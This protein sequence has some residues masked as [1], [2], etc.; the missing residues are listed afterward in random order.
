MDI[1]AYRKANKALATAEQLSSG[2]DHYEVDGLDLKIYPVGGGSPLVMTFTQPA[3]GKDG[4]DGK[5]GADGVSI[6]GVEVDANNRLIVTYSE[7]SPEVAGTIATV[8]GDK[9][10]PGVPG[11]AGADG[12][13]FTIK[14]QYP[15]EAALIAAHPTGQEGDAYFVGDDTNPDL[16]IWLSDDAEWYNAGKIAGIKGDKGDKGDPGEGVPAGGTT[17]QV[18]T[19]KSGSDYDAEW[20]NPAGG[21]TLDDLTD[22]DIDNPADGEALVYNNTSGKWENKD[23]ELGTAAALDVPASGDASTTEVVKGDDSR[24]TDARTPVSH[25]HTLSQVTDAGTAAAKD[26][27][28]TITQGSTDLIESGAVY[29]GLAGK[30]D[31]SSVGT[32]SGVAE[33]DAY[34]KVPASQLPSYVD[35]VVEGYYKEADGKFYE[36]STYETE[37]AGEADKIY[38]SKDTNIQYRWTGSAFAALGGALQLG[39][40]SSTAYRGDRGKTAYDFSQ[41]PYSSNPAM[42]GTASP[43]S[44]T[45]WAKGDHVHPS[46]TS[47]ADKSTVDGILDGQSIDSFGDVET[48][49][50]GKADT[51]DIPDITGKAD[52]VVNA[53][54]GN[55]AGLD[56]NGNPTDSGKKAS[57]FL[58]SDLGLSVVNGQICITYEV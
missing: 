41:A 20:K 33:L 11:A 19:K 9:G 50:A 1:I 6:T 15:T 25:T 48:A 23:L 34:G 45:A 54:D 46:D 24:L 51:T 36:E 38:I 17:G 28:N 16:Y 5:D 52:K 56:S 30:V 21:G 26:S 2:I 44:S 8:K 57:D 53:T 32:A 18:L 43:G 4:K 12:K 14:A 31:T 13:S 40:T 42:N 49:L 35:D 58:T 10:D 47:K 39:E 29:T 7:G 3:D 37:I 22:T 55:F 27:T